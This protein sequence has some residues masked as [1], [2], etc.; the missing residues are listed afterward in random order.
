M[1]GYHTFGQE[2]TLWQKHILI[3]EDDKDIRE[4]I[5]I[6]LRN[7]GYVVFQAA[8]GIEGLNVIEKAFSPFL[9]RPTAIRLQLFF[10]TYSSIF[11]LL[12]YLSPLR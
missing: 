3:V 4:G 1:E 9:H 12:N 8:D 6:Y 2:N 10:M 7:Q 5:E 11:L